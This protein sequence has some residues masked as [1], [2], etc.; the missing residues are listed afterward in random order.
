MGVD[1]AMEVFE[2]WSAC[3]SLEVMTTSTAL[4]NPVFVRNCFYKFYISISVD[5]YFHCLVH[6]ML[7]LCFLNCLEWE[8]CSAISKVK[9]MNI[10]Q[11][12]VNF[13][14]FSLKTHHIALV[15]CAPDLAAFTVVTLPCLFHADMFALHLWQT[16][17]EKKV[18][19]V[20]YID[21]EH[22]D[23]TISKVNARV[24]LFI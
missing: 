12:T 16:Y 21:Y 20:G 9:E 8:E 10:A 11:K 24:R 22:K 23:N 15:V 14:L 5:G 1:E 17:F 6:L 7:C 19:V 18:I 2:M 4:I 13:F 3:C